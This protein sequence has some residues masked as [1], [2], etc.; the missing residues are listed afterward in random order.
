MLTLKKSLCLTKKEAI[1]VSDLL[2]SLAAMSGTID[3]HFTRECQDALKLHK[4][5]KELI[6]NIKDK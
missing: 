3:E 1:K 4:K 5:I 6:S 2:A